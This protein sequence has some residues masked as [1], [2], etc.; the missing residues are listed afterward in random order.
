[1]KAF[2]GRAKR[3]MLAAAP[4][5]GYAILPGKMETFDRGLAKDVRGV[6]SEI[7]VAQTM[8]WS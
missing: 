3:V 6:G 7:A 1:M 5:A 4:L 2:I 8:S